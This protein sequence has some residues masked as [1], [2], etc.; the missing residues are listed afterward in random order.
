MTKHEIEILNIMRSRGKTATDIA[1]ALQVSVNTV[2]SYI[3]SPP[4]CIV[5]CVAKAALPLQAGG[6]IPESF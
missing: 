1:L 3:R 2:R 4:L 6:Q 5:E